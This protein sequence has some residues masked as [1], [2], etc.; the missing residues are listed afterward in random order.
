[1]RS[2]L[3]TWRVSRM[4]SMADQSCATCRVSVR[5][6]QTV[7]TPTRIHSYTEMTEESTTTSSILN[8]VFNVP[9]FTVTLA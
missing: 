2:K 1:M 9:D 5:R 6:L 4:C 7:G 8:F 3:A